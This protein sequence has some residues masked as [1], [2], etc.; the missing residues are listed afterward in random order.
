MI[1]TPWMLLFALQSQ[2]HIQLASSFTRNHQTSKSLR[3]LTTRNMASKA[4]VVDPF[5]FRQF[6]GHEASKKYGGA[7]L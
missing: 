2:S 4:L 5:C 7:V 1:K 3:Q 6:A